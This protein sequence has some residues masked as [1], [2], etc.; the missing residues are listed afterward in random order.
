TVA[1]TGAR[2]RIAKRAYIR[3][4]GYAN[5][6]F[7]SARDKLKAMGGWRIYEAPCGHDVM[8]DMPERLV[9]GLG[10]GEGGELPTCAAVLRA[11]GLALV[12]RTRS[13]RTSNRKHGRELRVQRGT[14]IIELLVVLRFR[15]SHRA[16]RKPWRT[17][18]SDHY[19]SSADLRVAPVAL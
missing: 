12:P 14:R 16:C 1:V 19:S 4:V 18:E 8:V 13:S 3:A 10:A 6:P 5:P 17:S 2:N 7:D 15:G 9:G 11:R